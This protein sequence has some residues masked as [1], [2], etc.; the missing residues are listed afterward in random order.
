MPNFAFSD[1]DPQHRYEI[2][3]D[4][5]LF[6]NWRAV[7][8][9]TALDLS[10]IVSNKSTFLKFTIYCYGRFA[11]DLEN[12]RRKAAVGAAILMTGAASK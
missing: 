4:I 12:K 5:R 6:L 9:I 10:Y 1:P 3:T 2:L 11:N 7:F 8:L